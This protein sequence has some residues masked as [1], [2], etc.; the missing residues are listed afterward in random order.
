MLSRHGGL[1]TVPTGVVVCSTNNN[2]DNNDSWL[3]MVWD[4]DNASMNVEI[5]E[6]KTALQVLEDKKRE[7]ERTGQV[8]CLD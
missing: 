1:S 6:P 5:S 3:V 2:N 4:D 8:I 7:A